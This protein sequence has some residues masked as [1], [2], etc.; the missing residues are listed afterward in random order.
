MARSYIL[1]LR[2]SV[3]TD[4]VLD[5]S[6][7]L[8]EMVLT[9][10]LNAPGILTILL[11]DCDF[12]IDLFDEDQILNVWA[13]PD[14]GNQFLVGERFWLLKYFAVER[15][16]NSTRR[17][18]LIF[19][20]GIDWL[21][22]RGV[23]Y[24]SEVPESEAI[25]EPCDDLIK[26]IM[27]ENGSVAATTDSY[28]I[29]PDPERDVD[30]WILV[31]ADVGA[32]P[33]I[34]ESFEHRPLL[35]VMQDTASFSELQGTRLY[36]DIP[37]INAFGPPVGELRTYI[38]QR[39]TDRTQGTA[40]PLVLTPYNETIGEYTVGNDYR[41]SARRAYAG[42]RGDGGARVFA[43]ATDVGLAAYLATHP[44]ALRETFVNASG[45]DP[46]EASFA[47]KLQTE[48]D[49][50]LQRALP[51]NQFD[52]RITEQDGARYGVNWFFGDRITVAAEGRVA[53]ADIN[54]MTITLRNG[55]ETID[56]RVSTSINRN[57]VT[58]VAT[59]PESVAAL[60]RKVNGLE[61]IEVP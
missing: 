8:T 15:L 23:T 9:M 12:D 37:Q 29:A 44:L 41:K 47:A 45:L 7:A 58:G 3:A 46:A 33:N 14:G 36:F 26:R 42:S 50:T 4:T 22:R 56:A 16:A 27:R 55:S 61:V 57:S 52:G 17:I 39:G 40:N 43:T 31:Q 30:A 48:A 28:N 1:H 5:L 54:A 10:R 13:K 21:S 2:N 35:T 11:D 59:I 53:D 6:D 24:E 19:G 25:A 18:K 34:D 38:G 49:V 20:D 51:F 60:T 32:A